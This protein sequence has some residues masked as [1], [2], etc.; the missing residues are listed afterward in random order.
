MSSRILSLPHDVLL[1]LAGHL[2]GLEDFSNLCL[3]CKEMRS[4]LADALPN[5]ILR[6]AVRQSHFSP[7][8]SSYLLVA[9]TARELGNWARKSTTN[10]ETLATAFQGGFE[11]LLGLALRQCS[12]TMSQLRELQTIQYS[13]VNPVTNASAS[14]QWRA[15]P[16]F[17]SGGASDAASISADA[18]DSFFHIAVYGELFSPDIETYLNGNQ[19]L[20]AQ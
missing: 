7:F 15:I 14:Q 3:T 8:P 9:A 16:D 18:S 17:W 4:I 19:T 5:T 6:I 2:Y 11:G 10:E 20:P 1:L 13:I 12:L